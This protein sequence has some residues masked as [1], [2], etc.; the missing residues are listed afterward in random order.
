MST[1]TPTPP[2]TDVC[3]HPNCTTHYPPSEGI[4]GH[5]THTCA[6]RHRGQRLLNLLRYDHRFCY[7]CFRQL[8]TIDKPSPS[9]PECVI[10][11]QYHTHHA[12][13]GQITDQL[14][15]YRELVRI[16]T[17][18][19]CGQTDHAAREP[20]IQ[21]QDFRQVVANLYYAL[22]TVRQEGQHDH[23]LDITALAETLREQTDEESWDFALAVGQ[24]IG[25]KPP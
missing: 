17:I 19:R 4:N 12:T 23:D 6:T 15:E 24:A 1:A 9:A 25:E 16:G 8:K 2:E 18:C 3:D 11:F 5:C 21:D 20:A 10:G 14:D 22:E 7:K 13:T